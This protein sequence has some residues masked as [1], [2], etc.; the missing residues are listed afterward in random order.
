MLFAKAVVVQQAAEQHEQA[1]GNL[2]LG[3]QEER[4]R[5]AQDEQDNADAV[6]DFCQPCLPP[7]EDAACN[8]FG[9]FSDHEG[10]EALSVAPTEDLGILYFSKALV[11]FWHG[12]SFLLTHRCTATTCDCFELYRACLCFQF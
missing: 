4:E 7:E 10:C 2:D 12:P 11:F 5:Q 9:D 3:E 6:L 8:L 1:S